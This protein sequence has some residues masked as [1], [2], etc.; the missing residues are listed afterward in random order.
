[1]TT[2]VMNCFHWIGYHIVD[3]LLQQGE[4]VYGCD[5]VDTDQKDHLSMFFGRNDQFTF[6]KTIDEKRYD[7]IF[8]IEQQNEHP[9]PSSHRAVRIGTREMKQL[10]DQMIDIHIPYLVGEW[11]P[12]ANDGVR[13]GG[14]WIPFESNLFIQEAIYVKDFIPIMLQWKNHTFLEPALTVRSQHSKDQ[15][16]KLE[17]SI[18]IRDNRPNN[19]IVRILKEHY[20]RHSWYYLL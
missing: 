14:E 18:S 15:N 8:I 3:H 17:N 4:K 5:H 11:M 1:M 12:M 20:E 2:L 13:I 19:T 10:D 6:C 16:K 9:L 7:D